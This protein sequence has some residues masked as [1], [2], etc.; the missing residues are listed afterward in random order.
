MIE[1]VNEQCYQGQLLTNNLHIDAHLGV[2]QD[3]SAGRFTLNFKDEMRVMVL[4]LAL[5]AVI[6][7][8]QGDMIKLKLMGIMRK[9]LYWLIHKLHKSGCGC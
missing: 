6:F 8:H 2:C 1:V 9:T 4:D 5:M 3:L 7:W